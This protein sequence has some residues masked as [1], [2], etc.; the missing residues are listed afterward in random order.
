M[1]R[2]RPRT[3]W[4]AALSG[5]LLASA[6]PAAGEEAEPGGAMATDRPEGPAAGS[7]PEAEQGARFLPVPIL[8][9]SP[10]T[11]FGAGASALYL[12]AP[13]TDE[14]GREIAS[15]VSVVGFATQE[16]QFLTAAQVQL[17]LDHG[18]TVVTGAASLSRF[19]GRF[20]GLGNDTRLA[21]EEDYTPRRLTLEA[22]GLR[23]VAGPFR[24]GIRLEA[25]RLELSEIEEDGFFTS[26]GIPG[27]E[28]GWASG[29]VALA[30]LDSRDRRHAPSRGA[31]LRAEAGFFARPLGSDYRYRTGLLDAR[32]YLGRSGLV[33]AV[34]GLVRASGR[35]TPFHL[36]PALGGESLLRGHY[37]GRFRDRTL[38]AVQVEPRI[39]VV[40]RLS[41][42]VFLGAGEVAPAAGALTLDGV[43]VSGGAGIRILISEET[44]LGL[45]LDQGF[46]RDESG[47]YV[48]LGEAF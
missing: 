27:A 28:G 7:D 21:A 9:Y 36:L 20:Y 40:G 2:P 45:R 22:Q 13:D 14:V 39:R 38:A 46:A 15:S 1:F 37:E 31:Y 32:G 16:D 19:P 10:E 4:L 3:L 34:R 18:R 47:F 29:V 44:G 17:Y 35:E 12:A 41:A 25:H 5:A 43:H 6:L 33:L 48:S 23:T 42:A 26:G 30:E 8:F 11:R 24:A